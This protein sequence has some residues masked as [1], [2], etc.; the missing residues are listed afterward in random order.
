MA[1]SKGGVGGELGARDAE[2]ASS[3]HR[4]VIDKAT[5]VGR[6]AADAYDWAGGCAGCESPQLSEQ[7]GDDRIE[8]A[9]HAVDLE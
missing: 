1:G 8:V 4:A 2:A 6:A 7:C 3:R 5:G 9:L